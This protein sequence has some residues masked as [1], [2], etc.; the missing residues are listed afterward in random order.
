MT[1]SIELAP[2]S[3]LINGAVEHSKT[4][5]IEH[6]VVT[7]IEDA[8]RPADFGGLLVPGF[9]DTQ[10]NGGGGVLFNDN[11]CVEAIEA[12]GA[13]HRQFG[14]TSFLPTLISDDLDKVALAI[15][16]VDEAIAAGV[17]G[18]EGIHLEGPFLN[19]AKKG[20]H[21]ASK[22]RHL[23]AG[24]V[25]LLGSLKHGKTLL[26]I[27]P[28]LVEPDLINDLVD[29]GIV[30]SAGH[31][32]AT[33]E[34]MKEAVTDGVSGFTHLFNAMSG[35]E[36]RAPGV[37]GAAFDSPETF[38]GFIADGHH[39]HAASLRHAM[40]TLGPGRSM[41]VT[42]AM[43]TV[44]S[45]KNEFY[46]GSERITAENGYCRNAA[47]V[48]AGSDLDMMSAV[49]F[50]VE[51]LGFALH[52]AVEMASGTP[53]RFMGLQSKVGTIAAGNRADFVLLDDALKIQSV[54]MGGVSIHD[55]A[56]TP[57]LTM[58]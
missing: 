53:A 22:F 36:S 45:E 23:S 13:A 28:E 10:V 4:I 44:G 43:P 41:L 42:D 37:V 47:G 9:F 50:I 52:E 33:Y 35:F 20:I 55:S 58:V 18:V 48:L 39:V 31:T 15:K 32:S 16:A 40:R 38:A 14:T 49:R 12:I 5:T 51:T 1:S 7:A 2:E 46:L 11:P 57:S 25:E 56:S 24:D 8:D 3:V 17:P 34:Q 29:A 19:A 6:G 21:D 30:L 27:A 54:W 26:T